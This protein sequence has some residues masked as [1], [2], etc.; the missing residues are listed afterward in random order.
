[1]FGKIG[2]AKKH[3]QKLSRTIPPE[4]SCAFR[5]QRSL[6]ITNQS[7]K[8]PTPR[9]HTKKL[10]GKNA[11]KPMGPDLCVVSM[12]R[13]EKVR[14][15]QPG[16]CKG[17]GATLCSSGLPQDCF[18]GT[19]SLTWLRFTSGPGTTATLIFACHACSLVKL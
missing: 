10:D 16:S 15:A 6:K 12:D 4:E 5:R 3:T 8:K 19:T 7:W 2:S 11:G 17:E 9:I 14:T 18:K 13:P 1:M